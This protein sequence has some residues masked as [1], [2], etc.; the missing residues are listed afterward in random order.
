MP[1]L[2]ADDAV[3]LVIDMQERLQ[4]Q[5]HGDARLRQ[6]AAALAAGMRLLDVPVVVTEQY[7]KGLGRTVPELQEA[8]TAAGGPLEK[9]SF[10]CGDDPGV[11]A[12]L[13]ALGR[14]TVLLAGVEAHICVL[15]TALGLQEAG[16]RVQVVEDAVGSRSAEDKATGL[17]RLRMSGV[18]PSTVEMALFEVMGGSRH[19]RF[20]DVQALIK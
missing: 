14:R 5:I 8:A 18:E 12:R 17:A 11:R 6:R 16:Y 3:L 20:K 15:Q 7:P 10:A 9:T 13:D 1:R 19:P 2:R 4:P